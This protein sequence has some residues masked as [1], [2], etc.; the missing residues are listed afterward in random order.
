MR[1]ESQT[2]IVAQSMPT[3]THPKPETEKR[4]GKAREEEDIDFEYFSD[5]DDIELQDDMEDEDNRVQES[6]S[7]PVNVNTLICRCD[8]N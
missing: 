3:W 4:A 5:N 2:P 6:T 1:R 7:Q 8:L